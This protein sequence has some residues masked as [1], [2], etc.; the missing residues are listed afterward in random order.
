[1]GPSPNADTTLDTDDRVRH[2][3]PDARPNEVSIVGK[4]AFAA[5]KRQIRRVT[6]IA[7]VGIALGVTAVPAQAV[8]LDT[9]PEALPGQSSWSGPWFGPTSSGPYLRLHIKG[10]K[11]RV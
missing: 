6:V 7:G 8:R 11:L 3:P 9:L 10:H 1:M 2:T 5:A 4:T